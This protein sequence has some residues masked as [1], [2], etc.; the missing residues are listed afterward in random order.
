MEKKPLI[1]VIDDEPA[2]LQTL[3]ESLEDEQFHV[4]TL[5]DGSNVI[6][7]IGALIPDLVLLDIFLPKYNG[8]DLLTQIKKEYPAQNVMMISGFGTIS[9]AIDAIKKGAKDFIEKPLNLDEILTKISYLKKSL[10]PHRAQSNTA[11][12]KKRDPQSF[13]I[14]GASSLFNELIHYV[15]IVAPLNLP[16][17]MYGP[18]GSGKTMLAQYIHANSSMSDH[19]FIMLNGTSL[20][21]I[22][23]TVLQ[24]TGTLFIKNIHDLDQTVQKQILQYLEQDNSTLRLITSST[25]NLFKLVQDGIFNKSL[26]CKLNQTPIEIPSINKRRYDIPLLVSHFLKSLN[27]KNDTV[28]DISPTAIRLLRNHVWTGDIAQIKTVIETLYAIQSP[29]SE[30]IEADSLEKLFSECSQ[31][32]VEEQLYSRFNSIEQATDAFQ[33]RYLSHLLKTY[34]YDF[35]QL[36]EFLKIPTTQL[37]DTM[38]KL[39]INVK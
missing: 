8:L 15:S 16:I 27:E 26:F 21:D 12:S 32:F 18:T 1:L 23:K 36:A 34:R 5:A 17:L 4:Q 31:E 14:M 28:L 29:T 13:G 20:T 25:P 2:I 33:Q 38:V 37:H 35:A 6:Q 39:H 11:S 3:K 7:T 19:E 22:P 10:T 30:I 24:K 9:I